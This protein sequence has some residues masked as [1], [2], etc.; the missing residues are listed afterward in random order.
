MRFQNIMINNKFRNALINHYFNKIESSFK[1][2]FNEFDLLCCRL[3]EFI[4]ES[5]KRVYISDKAWWQLI[6]VHIVN[7]VITDNSKSSLSNAYGHSGPVCLDPWE[8]HQVGIVY[9]VT[10]GTLV[11]D[12]KLDQYTVYTY[13]LKDRSILLHRS[14]IL[15]GRLI[16]NT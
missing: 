11:R 7:V 6:I 12:T 1:A 13:T 15:I 10:F 16:F 8:R 4:I 14:C 3:L 9:N 2:I 5:V